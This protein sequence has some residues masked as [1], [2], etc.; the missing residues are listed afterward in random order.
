MSPFCAWVDHSECR[1]QFGPV[2]PASGPPLPEF[3]DAAEPIEAIP[4]WWQ[5]L[6]RKKTVAVTLKLPSITAGK[7]ST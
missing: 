1:E 6:G 3:S 5:R 2:I 7:P 4:H